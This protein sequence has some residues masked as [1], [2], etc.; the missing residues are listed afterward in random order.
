MCSVTELAA[1]QA[2]TDVDCA[3][4]ALMHYYYYYFQFRDDSYGQVVGIIDRRCGLGPGF[5]TIC[6]W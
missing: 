1:E 2:S 4:I 6:G 5:D 3:P